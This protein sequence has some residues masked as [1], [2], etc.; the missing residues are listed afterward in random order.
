MRALAPGL[1]ELLSA[2]SASA[3]S[4]GAKALAGAAK[5]HVSGRVAR[6]IEGAAGD[7]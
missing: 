4:A 3:R 7:L 1:D 6:L 5:A 2:D